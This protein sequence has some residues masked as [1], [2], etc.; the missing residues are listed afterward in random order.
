M[1][2]QPNKCETAKTPSLRNHNISSKLTGRISPPHKMPQKGAVHAQS[3]SWNNTVNLVLTENQILKTGEQIN[4]I[5]MSL[6]KQ[7]KP[8]TIKITAHRKATS[9][10]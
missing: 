3:T 6:S 4:E 9:P 5:L 8:A 7:K 2:D 1:R 10:P